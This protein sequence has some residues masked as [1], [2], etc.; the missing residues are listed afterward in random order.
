MG[1]AR[2]L[3]AIP[4]PS[5]QQA[6]ALRIEEEGLF[7]RAAEDRDRLAGTERTFREPAGREHLQADAGE[8]KQREEIRLTGSDDADRFS[9][10]RFP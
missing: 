3:L 9:R 2:A 6:L 7:G 5:A 10:Y 8:A 4:V 1:H